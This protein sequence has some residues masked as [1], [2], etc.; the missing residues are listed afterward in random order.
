[1][2]SS[3][4]FGSNPS[5]SFLKVHLLNSR[6]KL[7]ERK[8]AGAAGYDLCASEDS[9]IEA[10]GHQLVA[11]GI[12][13]QCPEGTYARVA[14][15]SGLAVRGI[16]VGAGVVDHDYR[17]EVKVLLVNLGKEAFQVQAGD[18]I[19]QLILERILTP[20]VAAVQDLSELSDT[21]RGGA[22][23]GSTGV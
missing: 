15:R 9:L 1:M 18:R 7:P 16:H 4:G 13:M 5:S 19:A 3:S 12:A 6:A 23:F 10:N 8:S 11:T 17:G 2:D 22:G 14:P 20:K 21:A